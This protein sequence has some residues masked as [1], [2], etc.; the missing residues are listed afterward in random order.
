MQTINAAYTN[1]EIANNLVQVS[2]AFGLYKLT[3]IIHPKI[4]SIATAMIVMVAIILTRFCFSVIKTLCT[5][6]W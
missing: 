4:N 1:P 2:E 5:L 3:P 6:K